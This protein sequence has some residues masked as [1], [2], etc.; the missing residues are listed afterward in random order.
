MGVRAGP[1]SLRWCQALSRPTF[2]TASAAPQSTSPPPPVPDDAPTHRQAI[3]ALASPSTTPPPQ[4]STFAP[5]LHGIVTPPRSDTSA[6]IVAAIVHSRSRSH[7]SSNS[8]SGRSSPTQPKTGTVTPIA[9]AATSGQNRDRRLKP[10]TP[11]SSNASVTTI[12]APV[13]YLRRCLFVFVAIVGAT[14]HLVDGVVADTSSV[15]SAAAAAVAAAAAASNGNSALLP[16]MGFCVH[17]LVC[18]G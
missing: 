7:S 15:S 10:P 1:G 17:V 5:A 13:A 6:C 18:R 3:V 9:L 8:S 11:C 12:A 16:G 4:P 2:A 14:N